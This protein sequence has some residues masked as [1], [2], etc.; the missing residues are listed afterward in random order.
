MLGRR[1]DDPLAIEGAAGSTAGFGLL[2]MDTAITAKKQ[3]A[4]AT[5][6]FSFA[7]QVPVAGYEIHMGRSE[8][9]AL[10]SPAFFIDGRAEGVLSADG[11]VLG[12]YLHGLFDTPQALAA[13]LQWAGLHDAAPLD[14]AALRMHSLDRIADAAQPLLD[15]LLQLPA[16]GHATAAGNLP[17]VGKFQA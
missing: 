15:A 13:L 16:G 2:E 3:L 8:G 11:Q 5:G 17:D 1:I 4:Q 6:Y 14:L 9:P 7:P 10:A 12:T